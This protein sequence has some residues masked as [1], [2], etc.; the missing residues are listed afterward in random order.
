MLIP[1]HNVQLDV[2][3]K[4][5][6]AQVVYIICTHFCTHPRLEG[7]NAE[8]YDYWCPNA[9][10]DCCFNKNSNP[11]FVSNTSCY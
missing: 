4:K 11:F 7:R 5:R 1:M 8:L 6:W 9:Q 3:G 10:K 2:F